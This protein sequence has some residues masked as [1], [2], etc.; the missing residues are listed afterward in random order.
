MSE[1]LK[2][3]VQSQIELGKDR[4]E[5]FQSIAR[6]A[7]FDAYKSPSKDYT[8][9]DLLVATDLTEKQIELRDFIQEEF[10]KAEP[11]SEARGCLAK[12]CKMRILSGR[13]AV[14]VEEKD[15]K[16]QSLVLFDLLHGK[17]Q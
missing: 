8:F 13:Y 3:L 11:S 7:K 17:R 5:A 16:F 10:E 15:G 9:D 14:D 2:K 4:L 12:E 6:S 1:D